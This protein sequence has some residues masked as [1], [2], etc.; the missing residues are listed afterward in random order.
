[1]KRR[2]A[3]VDLN[4]LG[5]T[6]LFTVG[7]KI[8]CWQGLPEGSTFVY[9][10]QEDGRIIAVFYHPSF[11]VVYPGCVIPVVEVEFI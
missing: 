9:S 3:G 10:Y 7:R 8:Q 2:F 4:R 6:D 11:E 5:I 1:M